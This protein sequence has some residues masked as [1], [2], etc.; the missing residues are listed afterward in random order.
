MLCD[1]AIADCQQLVDSVPDI[2]KLFDVKT[3]EEVQALLDG[4]LSSDTSA[5]ASSSETQRGKQQ[6]GESVDQAF[7][8]F[9]SEE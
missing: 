2:D 3:T 6:T 7:A 4:Y 1:D 9:M 8:A 5:E